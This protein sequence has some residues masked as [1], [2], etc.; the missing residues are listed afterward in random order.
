ML[1]KCTG[2]GDRV[3]EDESFKGDRCICLARPVAGRPSDIIASGKHTRSHRSTCYLGD[4]ISAGIGCTH[5]AITKASS[6]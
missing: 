5:G 3:I 2:V 6:T 4:T 1:R